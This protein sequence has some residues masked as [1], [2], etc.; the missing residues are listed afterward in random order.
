MTK[1][2][3]FT[4]CRNCFVLNEKGNKEVNKSDIY[5]DQKLEDEIGNLTPSLAVPGSC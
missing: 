5:L 2:L 4:L 3:Y 1:V